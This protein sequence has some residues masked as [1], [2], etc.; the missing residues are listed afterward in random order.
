MRRVLTLLAVIVATAMVAWAEEKGKDNSD[1][2]FDIE[3]PLLIQNRSAEPLPGAGTT[4]A[5]TADVDP[6]RLEKQLERARKNAA[7]AEHL[8]KIGVLARLDVEQCALKIV[9]LEGDLANA[10][11]AGAKEEFAVQES[12]L[13]AGEISKA[14]CAPAEA[15]LAHAIETAHAAAANRE[16]A[17]LEAAELNLHRQEKLLALGSARKSDVNRAEERLAQLRAPKD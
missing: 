7:G 6:A 13:T 5:S 14:D 3:P 15:A 10:R 8:Y 4:A 11:L 2:S 12:R 9:R 17:E 16:R 1:E